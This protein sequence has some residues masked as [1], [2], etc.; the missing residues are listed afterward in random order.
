MTNRMFVSPSDGVIFRLSLGEELNQ[1]TGGITPIPNGIIGERQATASFY[2]IED[3]GGSGYG[4]GES[5]I[6]E[7][8]ERRIEH[9]EVQHEP[10]SGRILV[11]EDT[12]DALP[13]K[14]YILFTPTH[15]GYSVDYLA[16]KYQINLEEQGFPTSPPVVILLSEDRAWVGGKIIPISRIP[17][18]KHP[19][20][21]G[22]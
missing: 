1:D 19:F 17:K 15:P 16:P 14:R 8:S 9:I 10:S 3:V 22:G 7:G 6:P 4:E 2:R 11:T 18:S 20:S 13:C 12:S 21:L 5:S